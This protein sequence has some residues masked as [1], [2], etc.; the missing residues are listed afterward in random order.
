METAMQFFNEN[1]YVVYRG[2]GVCRYAGKEMKCFDGKNSVEYF[3][4][5]PVNSVNSNYYVPIDKLEGK[6]KKL[7]SKDELLCI[8][9]GLPS[10]AADFSANCRERKQEFDGIMKNEDYTEMLRMIF[11]IYKHTEKIKATG[12][13]MSAADERVFRAAES[14]L[15]PE[16]A[17]VLGIDAENVAQFITE[18]LEARNTQ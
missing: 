9:D 3:K 8:I 5:V 6:I 14:R 2:S 1:D 17:V 12:K 7:M 4:F 18:R 10:E 13:R 11:A 15:Y 16:F